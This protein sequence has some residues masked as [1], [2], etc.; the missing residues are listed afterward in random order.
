RLFS[1]DHF[2]AGHKLLGLGLAAYPARGQILITGIRAAVLAH[3][4]PLFFLRLDFPD[5]PSPIARSASCQGFTS[6]VTLCLPS[7][8]ARSRIASMALIRLA[9][10]TPFLSK[11]ILIRPFTARSDAARRRFSAAS[12]TI[13]NCPP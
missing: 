10:S 11:A 6:M 2:R 12:L 8:P 7:R 1:L 9:S 4:S 13:G 5:S 3:Q